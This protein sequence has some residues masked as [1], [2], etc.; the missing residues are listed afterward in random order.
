MNKVK[1]FQY[2]KN[3][4]CTKVLTSP[5]QN[6]KG[7]TNFMKTIYSITMPFAFLYH[8]ALLQSLKKIKINAGMNRRE[9]I[10]K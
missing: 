7:N 9:E 3:T 1:Q 4:T 5:Q 2:F 8:K 10:T 6:F